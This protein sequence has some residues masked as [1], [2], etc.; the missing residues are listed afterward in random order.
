MKNKILALALIISIIC[1]LNLNSNSQ[2]AYMDIKDEIIRLHVKANSDTKEDQALKLKVR[3]KI[4]EET[5]PLLENSKSIQETRSIVEKNI[6][7]IKSIAQ[8]VVK[9]EG[10]EYDIDVYFGKE[11][12]PTRKYGELVLPAG[13]YETLLVTIG[14]GKGQNWWCV[15]FLPLCFV[16]MNHGIAANVE[17]DLSI[18]VANVDGDSNLLLTDNNPSFILKSKIV[19]LLE[20]TKLYMA[21]R[22]ALWN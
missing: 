13:E 11:N 9:E 4:L 5:K 8:Q 22:F 21:T 20:R 17:E 2:E 14:E 1:L 18:D 7:S 15:M 16:E 3:D 19:E 10:K 12:F 6:A